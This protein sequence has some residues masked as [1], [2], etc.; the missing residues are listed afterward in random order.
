MKTSGSLV[1]LLS[2]FI[3]GVLLPAEDQVSITPRMRQKTGGLSRANMR[4]DVQ[5]LQVA[6]TV[7]DAH[8]Q[9][10]TQ[11][12][13][14]SFRIFQDDVERPITT[15]SI[16]ETP[17]SA[18][19]VFD[20]SRSMKGRVGDARAAVEQFLKMSIPGDEFSLV[21]FNSRPELLTAMTRNSD[22]ISQELNWVEPRGW[23]AL[24]DAVFF[25]THEVRKGR[26][27]RKVLVVF[28]DGSDNNSRYSES[29]LISMLRETDVQVYTVSLF[30]RSRPLE[31]IAAETGGRALWLRKLD[32]LPSAMETITRQI[33]STYLIGCVP[34]EVKND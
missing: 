28:S 25:A 3:L 18:T 20:S 1:V 31:R 23:T 33:R 9:P 34:G 15:L 14:N 16:T 6:V 13:Q 29:E 8:G 26:N 7:T 24:F 12:Q 5:L 27:E 10:L 17:I 4:V 30:E 32:D 19:L 11:L 2:T 21:G 22:K